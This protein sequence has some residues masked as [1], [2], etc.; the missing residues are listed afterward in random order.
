[1]YRNAK[2]KFY[3]KLKLDKATKDIIKFYNKWKQQILRGKVN[4]YF[5]NIN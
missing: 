1:M 3:K 5:R 2:N 4:E